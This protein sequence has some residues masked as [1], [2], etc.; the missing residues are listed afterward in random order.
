MKITWLWRFK[1]ASSFSSGFT[2]LLVSYL[3]YK[4]DQAKIPAVSSHEPDGKN[5]ANP[6]EGVPRP[7]IQTLS[8]MIFGLALSIGAITQ[9]AQK[10]ADITDIAYSL[11]SFG[12]SFLILALVWINY[13]RIM[14]VL[15]VE[16]S[17]VTAA[18]M[19]LLFL[20]SIETYLYN[21][22][23]ASP[24]APLPG[25]LSLGTTT[26][27]YALDVGG[28]LIIL[29]YF[30]HE[31]TSEERHLIPNELMRGYR[32]MMY[33]TAIVA[34]IFFLSDLPIFWSVL[35]IQSPPVPLRFILWA[36]VSVARVGRRLDARM[37]RQR[38]S[39]AGKARDTR[40]DRTTSN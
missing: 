7:R 8:D 11:L 32:L 4:Q 25:Q 28:L 23:T 15:P 10:P 36:S 37:N 12:F 27:L 1:T 3:A 26:T 35:V 18:N 22:M 33:S 21:L 39:R 20:V 40:H 16:T 34:A 13:S 5:P 2:S 38:S 9:L 31:L 17:R 14:S 29:A 6:H 24:Y 19:L 30:T